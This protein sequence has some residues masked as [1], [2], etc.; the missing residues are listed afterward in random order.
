MLFSSKLS[1]T[2]QK[3]AFST[4]LYLTGEGNTHKENDVT[5]VFK[6]VFTNTGNHYSPITG[7]PERVFS[8]EFSRASFVN[9][10]PEIF[11]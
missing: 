1:Y 9:Q 7:R 6:T 3:V 10:T 11:E 4:S 8:F 2:G 5:L